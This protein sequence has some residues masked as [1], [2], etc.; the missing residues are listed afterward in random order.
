MQRRSLLLLAAAWPALSLAAPRRTYVATVSHVTDGD[1][2]WVRPSWGGPGIAV[3]LQGIDAPESCQAWGRQARDALASRVLHQPVTVQERG[4]DDYG[5]TLA[6]LAWNGMDLG[7]WLVFSGLA[8][9]SGF[10]RRRVR[11]DDLQ[12]QARDARRGLWAS[13]Q[14]TPPRTFRK[15]HGSCLHQDGR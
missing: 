11:Y 1:S 15:Q 3:R 10:L 4:H 2:V 8:W 6:R 9:S 13:L 5:R 14:P 12:R 7:G